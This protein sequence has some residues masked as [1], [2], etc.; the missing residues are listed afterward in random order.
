[1]AEGSSTL[2]TRNIEGSVS[3]N[4]ISVLS[5]RRMEDP[6]SVVAKAPS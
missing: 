1:M 6:V 2:L 3:G 4:A 5:N